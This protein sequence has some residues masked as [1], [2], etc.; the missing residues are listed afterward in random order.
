MQ[1]PRTLGECE[2]GTVVTLITGHRVEL[3]RENFEFPG[4][5]LVKNL[6]DGVVFEYHKTCRLKEES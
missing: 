1:E 2:F 5:L 6:D 4:W 3:L